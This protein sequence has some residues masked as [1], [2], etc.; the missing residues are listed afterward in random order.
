MNLLLGFVVAISVT[1]VLIPPL[2]KLAPRWRFVDIPED[3]KVHTNPIPR[4]GGIAMAVGVLL[5]WFVCGYVATQTAALVTGV[6]VLLGFGMWDDRV[7][8][9]A[10]PKFIGQAIAVLIVMLWGDVSIGS[11][12]L[13]ERY[14]LP[15][16]IAMPLTFIFLVGA[17]NAVNLSD[18]LDGLAGG[19]I[20]LCLAG[21]AMLAFSVGNS[22]VGGLALL[23][24]GAV[25]GFLR[26]NTYPARVFMGDSGSQLLGFCAAVL[27]VMLTQDSTAPLSAALP[28]LLLGIPIIDT[29]TVMTSRVLAGKSPFKADR[30]HIHHRLLTLGFDHHEAVM[31]IYVAQALLFL[32]A[33]FMRYD[34]DIAIA[35]TF[36]TAGTVLLSCL[37]YAHRIGWQWRD[38]HAHA[39]QKASLLRAIFLWASAPKRLPRWSCYLIATAMALYAVITLS[40]SAAPLKDAGLLATVAALVLAINIVW[41]WKQSE[42]SWIDKGAFY[43]A[44]A[45]VVFL[46][47]S[48]AGKL[49]EWNATL[50]T[51]TAVI[52]VSVA[53]RLRLQPER[54]FVVTPLDVLV[55]IAAVIIPNLPGSLAVSLVGT[56]VLGGTVV[57]L[58]VLFYG[59]ETLNVIAG[60][61]WRYLSIAALIVLVTCSLRGM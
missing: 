37:R 20:M 47:E 39:T 8:L 61:H 15:N 44:A 16:M 7:A 43:V 6:L 46:S 60:K 35:C 17:T 29:A 1:M 24:I 40:V 51:A 54:R 27:A 56:H 41:R 9:P 57:K 38:S 42:L 49:N 32:A 50:W 19:V 10:G 25:L 23:I 13:T 55:V 53:I 5:G 3:R 58:I 4:V 14:V 18:G 36:V 31:I 34:S 2:I 21:L 30:N 12:T 26:Y 59:I 48:G 22:L 33:W 11:L 45:I 28:L 52:A